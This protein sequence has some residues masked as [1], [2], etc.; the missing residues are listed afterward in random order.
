M[1]KILIL[2]GLLH[3]KLCKQHSTTE[4]CNFL[5]TNYQDA[6]SDKRKWLQEILYYDLLEAL[7]KNKH[8]VYRFVEEWEPKIMVTDDSK[9]QPA[10]Y[11]F[12]QDFL[13]YQ[14]LS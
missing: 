14:G 8:E 11:E 1:K 13:T 2:M 9:I 7:K 12:V 3:N 10:I 6:D 4:D 5:V